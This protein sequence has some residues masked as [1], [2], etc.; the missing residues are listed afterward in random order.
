MGGRRI[1]LLSVRLVAGL[2]VRRPAVVPRCGPRCAASFDDQ[3]WDLFERQAGR[4]EGVWTTFDD[5]GIEQNSHTAAWAVDVQGDAATHALEVP[6]PGDFPR[7]IPVG[8]YARGR[9]GRQTLAGA[10][11]ATGPAVLRSGLMATEVLLTRGDA[12]L[13]VSFQHAPAEPKEDAERREPALLLYRCVVARERRDAAPP[14]REAEAAR[15]ADGDDDVLFWRGVNPWAWRRTWGGA[16]AV[17][18]GRGALTEYALDELDDDDGCW[19][20]FMRTGEASY[21]LVLP[22]GVR[23]HAPQVIG[24]ETPAQIR[25]AWT[26]NDATLLRAEATVV[27]LTP[28]D[29]ESGRYLPPKLLSFRADDLENRGDKAGDPK[30]VDPPGEE[31]S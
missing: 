22:G 28:A 4:W 9:L 17:A 3:Q 19:H 25:V 27:A 11:M 14:T 10:G 6:G 18:T 21:N 5:Q 12:R 7:A 20:E 31:P 8:S 30:Y 24:P 29:D 23:I 15:A 26:P 1:L 16:S 2:V 13:R